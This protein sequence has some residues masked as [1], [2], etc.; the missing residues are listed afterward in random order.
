M[1]KAILLAGLGFGDEGKGS[2]VDH[3]VRREGAPLVVRYNGGAQAAHNV[4][5]DDGRHHTFAQ[6]GAG[7]FA[8]ARTFLSRHM[9]FNPTSLVPEARHLI[10][11]GVPDPYKL[12]TVDRAA[13]LTTPFHIAANRIR[14]IA[15]NNGRH[16]SCG[17]GIGETVAYVWGHD[18]AEVPLVEDLRDPKVLREKCALLCERLKA[19]VAHLYEPGRPAMQPEF[20]TL[21]EFDITFRTFQSFVDR[22]VKHVAIEPEEW[23]VSELLKDQTVVFEGAQG[24]LLDENHGFHPHTT[25]ST[26]TF[27]WADD[28][29]DRVG[30]VEKKRVGVLRGYM[31][32]HGHGPFVTEDGD[33]PVPAGEH[34]TLGRWQ[35]DFRMGHFDAV[36]ARYALEV[37]GGVDELALTCLDHLKG[38][39]Q[40]SWEYELRTMP[41]GP[42]TER[43]PVYRLSPAWRRKPGP[44]LDAHL[45]KQ[46]NLGNQLKT[47]AKPIY[48]ESYNIESFI[49]RV[50]KTTE[51]PVKILSYGP[52][53]SDKRPR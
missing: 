15:R 43:L 8:G 52:K 42:R 35:A 46:E 16:G 22:V 10:E 7:T 25:W 30:G 44:E 29:V 33:V 18:A 38:P 31:T 24:V 39:I 20:E 45:V 53:A 47:D 50:E 40:A 1:G 2:I 48:A 17:M 37:C 11:I 27:K 32:R 21:N 49:D 9:L 23:L 4:V 28:L 13:Y 41:G 51:V 19:D 12:L 3:L 36:M 5:T 26:T 34:N 6:F 14:E